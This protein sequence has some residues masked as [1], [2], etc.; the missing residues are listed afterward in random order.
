MAENTVETE[1]KATHPVVRVLNQHSGRI[2]GLNQEY[3]SITEKGK[4]SYI[5]ENYGFL[6]DAIVE[7]GQYSL[8][9]SDLVAIWS[10]AVKF[11]PDRKLRY[12]LAMMISSAY[13]IQKMSDQEWKR[14][15][16]SLIETSAL[17]EDVKKDREGLSTFGEG[18]DGVVGKLSV[19]PPESEVRENLA[20][21]IQPLM[22]F[23]LQDK[24]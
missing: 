15:P 11:F 23:V 24:N 21:G 9:P 10:E 16:R 4:D 1:Q 2:A 22:A 6:A 7:A 12:R 14:V 17:P 13:A 8:E 18:I 20:N 19:F 3:S 5:G